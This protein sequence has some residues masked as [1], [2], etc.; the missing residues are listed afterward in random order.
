METGKR[1]REESGAEELFAGATFEKL[2]HV[3][4]LQYARLRFL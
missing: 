4:S 1:E 2:E 3:A